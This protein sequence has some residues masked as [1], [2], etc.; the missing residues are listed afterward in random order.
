M[1]HLISYVPDPHPLQRATERFSPS[2]F[3]G[4]CFGLFENLCG[5]DALVGIGTVIR[6][7]NLSR[8]L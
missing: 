2:W 7:I 6:G 3:S 4:I 5:D 1:E 8:E